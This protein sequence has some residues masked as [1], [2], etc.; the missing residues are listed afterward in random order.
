MGAFDQSSQIAT[1]AD[2]LPARPLTRGQWQLRVLPFMTWF[3]TLLSVVLLAV[4]IADMVLIRRDINQPDSTGIRSLIEQTLPK[5]ATLP[6]DQ[7]RHFFRLVL[8]S[9]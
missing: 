6:S 2:H 3:I 5:S 7:P 1:G 9:Q 8:R 4:S